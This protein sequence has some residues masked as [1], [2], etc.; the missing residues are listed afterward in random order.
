MYCL[1]TRNFPGI[2]F[3]TTISCS[4]FKLS[5]CFHNLKEVVYQWKFLVPAQRFLELSSE[6]QVCLEFLENPEL[7]HWGSARLMVSVYTSLYFIHDT[8]LRQSSPLHQ[9]PKT[10]SKP[11]V[12]RDANHEGTWSVSPNRLR[13]Q[14]QFRMKLRPSISIP[15]SVWPSRCG[16]G[17]STS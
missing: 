4:S 8:F 5:I 9:L 13:F 14:A 7:L 1:E 2:P 12:L 16:G 15:K 3:S 11:E 6:C 10:I 17:V